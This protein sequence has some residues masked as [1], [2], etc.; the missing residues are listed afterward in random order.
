M[1]RVMWRRKG[2]MGN[3]RKGKGERCEIT[4]RKGNE[5]REREREK[6]QGSEVEKRKWI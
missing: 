1:V 5:R 3:E 6:E 4:R 2:G